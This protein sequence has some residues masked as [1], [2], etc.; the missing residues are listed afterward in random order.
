MSNDPLADAEPGETVTVE[1]TVTQHAD[2]PYGAAGGFGSDRAV[3]W[4]TIGAEVV[5][6]EFECDADD[7]QVTLEQEL[8]KQV[9]MHLHDDPID[10]EAHRARKRAE[11]RGETLP[12]LPDLPSWVGRAATL[13]FSL[14]VA[15]GGTWL[16]T[17][18]LDGA[19]TVNGEPL[20]FGPS[21]FSAL[22][23]LTLVVGLVVFAMPYLP[24]LV[25]GRG[26]V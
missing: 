16:A 20:T 15:L 10:I 22:A 13:A 14:S 18:P 17:R 2:A 11:R 7:I 6:S 9:P 23:A 25:R 1:H 3:E 8:T 24:G 4:R 21:V 5:P 12:D 19:V 26:A